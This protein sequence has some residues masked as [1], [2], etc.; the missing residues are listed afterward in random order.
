MRI[1][2]NTDIN[3]KVELILITRQNIY[4]AGDVHEFNNHEK[5]VR[6]VCRLVAG[7]EQ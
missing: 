2:I 4:H 6:C 7:S 5:D 3:K 1:D